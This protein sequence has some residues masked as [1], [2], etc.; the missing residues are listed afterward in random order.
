MIRR[1]F[2]WIAL[3]LVTALPLQSQDFFNWGFALGNTANN[4]L[5]DMVVDNAEQIYVVGEINSTLDFNTAP[6]GNELLTATTTLKNYVAKYA[7][8]GSLIWARL[9]GGEEVKSVALGPDGSIVVL[10]T[11]TGSANLDNTHNV[12][13]SLSNSASTIFLAFIDPASGAINSATSFEGTGDQIPYGIKSKS[14]DLYITGSFKGSIDLDVSNGIDMQSAPVGAAKSLFLTKYTSG[15]QEWSHTIAT[16]ADDTNVTDLEIDNN[17]AAYLIG[18]MRHSADF[19]NG[20]LTTDVLFNETQSYLVKYNTNGVFEYERRGTRV[21]SF[22]SIE[23]ESLEITDGNRIT[24]VGTLSGFG[25]IEGFTSSLGAFEKD[26]LAIAYEADGTPVVAKAIG[27]QSEQY[28]TTHAIDHLGNWIISGQG[29]GS[30]SDFDPGNGVINLIFRSSQT[31][32]YLA[33]YDQD[34]NFIWADRFEEKVAG[35]DGPEKLIAINGNLYLGGFL[36]TLSLDIEFGTGETLIG[37]P[38]GGGESIYLISLNN[39]EVSN[40]NQSLCFGQS[41]TLGSQTIT[42]TGTY[43]ELL[44]GASL[45]GK[46]SLVNLVISEV[47]AEINLNTNTTG[48]T[49]ANSNDGTVT[50][51]ASD[52]TTR[53]Y[54]YSIDG[55]N[56]QNSPDFNGLPSASY[57]ATV[58]DP[59]GCS[60]TQAFS[61]ENPA[62]LSATLRGENPDCSGEATGSLEVTATGG[63]APYAYSPDGISFFSSNR[64]VSQPAGTYTVTVRDASGQL[65]ITNMV[66]LIDPQPINVSVISQVNILCKGENNGSFTVTASGGAG[67]LEY[68]LDGTTFSTTSDFQNL[69]AGTYSITVRDANACTSGISVTITEPASAL[70]FQDTEVTHVSCEGQSDGVIRLQATGGLPPYYYSLDGAP[71]GESNSFSG[72]AP[73]TYS[74]M[75]KDANDCN[76]TQSVSVT[77]PSA[78]A[79]AV[80]SNQPVSCNG[81]LKG[82]LRVMATGGTSP[83]TYSIDGMSFTTSDTFGNLEAGNYTIQVRDANNCSTEVQSTVQAEPPFEGT[84]TISHVSCNGGSDGQITIN[85]SGG[86]A[87]YRYSLNGVNTQTSNTF[88]NLAAGRYNILVEDP[89]LCSFF[90]SA[91]VAEPSALNLT[92]S[93]ANVT[94]HGADD[95]SITTIATGGTAP[96]TYSINGTDFQSTGSFTNLTPGEYTLTLKDANDCLLVETQIISEPAALNISIETLNNISCHGGSDGLINASGQGGM[97]PYR[98]SLNG[99]DFNDNGQF[100]NLTAGSYNVTIIDA[101]S[102]S[103]TRSVDITQPQILTLASELEHIRCFG[104]SEGSITGMAEGGTAPYTYSLNGTDFGT[105]NFDN[106]AAGDYTLTVKDANDCTNSMAITLSQPDQLSN[107]LSQNDVTCFGEANGSATV[108]ALGGTAPYLYQLND[109]GFQ[110]N[111]VFSS[112]SAGSYDYTVQDA[113]GCTSNGSFQITEP[114]LLEGSATTTDVQCNGEVDGSISITAQGGTAPYRYQLDGGEFQESNNFPLLAAGIYAFTI[115][116]AQGCTFVGNI[117]ISEPDALTISASLTDINTITAVAGGGTTP[118]EYSLDGVNFQTSAVFSGLANGDYRVTVRDANGC[119]NS[120]DQSIVITALDWPA[121]ARAVSVY[122]NPVHERLTISHLQSGETIL[123]ITLEGKTLKQTKVDKNQKEVTIDLSRYKGH[124]LIVVIRDA[125]GQLIQRKRVIVSG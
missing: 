58:R 78:L 19:Q 76:F 117:S 57:T 106:L 125:N 74:V 121:L 14:D 79:L 81:D 104:Q 38:S 85:V 82:T 59:D 112:L 10:G 109:S 41:I 105:G 119:T 9:I 55:L 75:V 108:T 77:E 34:L 16:Q 5:N 120:A 94:C 6:D 87:P 47:K 64:L 97:A 44:S 15:S 50:I 49:T 95:G 110:T 3:T 37:S 36:T 124:I 111:A 22:S 54:E 18:T 25:N 11:F 115:S 35:R 24:I 7:K 89:S 71:F 52:A 13:N 53:N 61:I 23:Y 1:N 107:T 123:L 66:T 17:D 21:N 62:G 45:F 39:V 70:D 31:D 32:T 88:S 4:K 60:A 28:A 92:T 67:T 101:N 118:Y 33:K 2:I 26:I 46:D 98:F 65:F 27:G 73:G 30:F 99:V 72:L 29:E 48:V 42:Q 68:A 51:I 91:T 69:A 83:Y 93:R 100:Q 43:Q 102:C 116:D 86:T 103:T 96:Y 90:V 40:Q 122:P 63:T 84:A 20:T 113:N 56:F 114:V 80:V 8:S 12:A